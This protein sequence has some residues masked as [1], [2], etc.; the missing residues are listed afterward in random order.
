MAGLLYLPG[1]HGYSTGLTG[2]TGLVTVQHSQS[3]RR[4]P[5]YYGIPGASWVLS[6]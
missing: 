6:P 5:P 2:S 1:G 3:S 4:E